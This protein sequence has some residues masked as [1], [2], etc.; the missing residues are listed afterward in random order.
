LALVVLQFA[1][2]HLP[3]MHG[4]FATRSVGL[5]G[6]LPILGIGVNPLTGFEVDKLVHRRL[7]LE[8]RRLEAA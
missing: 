6:G 5:R 3:V 2:T 7:R 4:F 1:F 8:A